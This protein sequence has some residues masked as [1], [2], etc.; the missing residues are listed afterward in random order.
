M[1]DTSRVPFLEARIADDRTT[2]QPQSAEARVGRRRFWLFATRADDDPLLR[3]FVWHG[4]S[5]FGPWT[6]HAQNPVVCDVRRARPA[7]PLFRAHGDLI[8]PG[9]DSSRTYGGALV[10]ARV[11]TLTPEAY[12]E[13]VAAVLRP[14]PAGPCPHG[15]HHICPVGGVAVVDGKRWRLDALAW[16]LKRRLKRARVSRPRPGGSSG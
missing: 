1:R 16:P 15:V 2:F 7:G 5:P 3:L 13:E 10:L 4:P 11:L 14:D 6:P 8:R 12:E 9:Q